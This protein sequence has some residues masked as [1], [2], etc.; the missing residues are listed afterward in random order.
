MLF[1][2]VSVSLVA[3]L[4]CCAGSFDLAICELLFPTGYSP[5][6][7]LTSLSD[8]LGPVFGGVRS[9]MGFLI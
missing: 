3:N 7:S 9:R 5:E 8:W 1:P 2:Q 6:Y 4:G